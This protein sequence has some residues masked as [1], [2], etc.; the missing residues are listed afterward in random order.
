MCTNPRERRCAA[1]AKEVNG[2]KVP[3]FPG[4]KVINMQDLRVKKQGDHSP[5][6]M[7]GFP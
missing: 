3:W 5:C 6:E 1:S 7:R 4:V 2:K